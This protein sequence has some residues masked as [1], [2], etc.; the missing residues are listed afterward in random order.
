MNELGFHGQEMREGRPPWLSSGVNFHRF[1]LRL[2]FFCF[3]LD[4]SHPASFD[5]E[6]VHSLINAKQERKNGQ[7]RR[8]YFSRFAA[9][10][11]TR[12]RPCELRR[13]GGPFLGGSTGHWP[14]PS[15]ESP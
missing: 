14:L 8:N 13:C 12:L 9:A 4:E 5:K 7:P 11:L 2:E 10:E 6:N 15:G 1:C 3:D